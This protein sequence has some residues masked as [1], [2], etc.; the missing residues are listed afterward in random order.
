MDFILEHA[1]N[2]AKVRLNN[3]YKILMKTGIEIDEGFFKSLSRKTLI[4]MKIQLDVLTLDP[5]KDADGYTLVD[6]DGGLHSGVSK[7]AFEKTII[8]LKIGAMVL[9]Q[10]LATLNAQADI[11]TSQE[12]LD[13]LVFND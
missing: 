7:T 9:W 12:Q 3:D 2:D 13:G 6:V 11:C 1:I 5:S 10:E 4:D 8:D